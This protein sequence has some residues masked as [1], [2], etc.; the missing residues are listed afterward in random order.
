MGTVSYVAPV[1]SKEWGLS[2]TTL[3]TIFSSAFLGLGAGALLI[4]PIADRFGRRPLIIF[5]I[6]LT[7]IAMIASGYCQNVEQFIVA[8]IATGLGVGILIPLLATYIS[9]ICP[10]DI[11]NV[12]M[13]ILFA[14]GTIGGVLGGIVVAE[15]LDI[16]GWRGVFIGGGIA[17]L[18]IAIVA[19]RG[20]PESAIFLAQ[21]ASPN[22]LEKTNTVLS[23]F[24][25]RKLEVLPNEKPEIK[26]VLRIFSLFSNEYTKITLSVWLVF[27]FINAYGYF[28]FSWIPQMLVS[29]GLSLERSVYTSVVHVFGGTFGAIILGALSKWIQLRRLVIFFLASGF[30]AILG[31]G[32]AIYFEYWLTLMVLIFIA[33]F[34]II[35]AFGSIYTITASYYHSLIRATAI[36]SCVGIARIGAIFG[37][38]ITGVLL[39]Y[40]TSVPM[41]IW[42][43]SIPVLCSIILIYNLPQSAIEIGQV[44]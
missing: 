26:S 24:K 3:G 39:D 5:A 4:T 19:I 31:L 2:S 6:F 1:L 29:V 40:G 35:G 33:G 43:F 30:A 10:S 42:L 11:R 9:E 21:S 8:R 32:I 28:I 25:S 12:N 7:G 16:L 14:S 27:I 44:R 36:G 20:L 18:L 22:A 37:P 38:F 41:C 17:T 34:T 23:K 15:L 13:G